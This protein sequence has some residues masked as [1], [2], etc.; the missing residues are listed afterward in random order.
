M[1]WMFEWFT[2]IIFF[3]MLLSKLIRPIVLNRFFPY[4]HRLNEF[5]AILIFSGH[6]DL[7]GVGFSRSSGVVYLPSG[8]ETRIQTDALRARVKYSQGLGRQGSTCVLTTFSIFWL[9]LSRYMPRRTRRF[10]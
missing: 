9:Q 5:L 1:A 4:V 2:P 8:F 6:F 7:P 3:S 10:I